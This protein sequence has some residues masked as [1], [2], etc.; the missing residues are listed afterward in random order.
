MSKTALIWGAGGGIGGALARLLKTEDWQVIA[1]ARDAGKIA[2]FAPLAFEADFG[3][4]TMVQTVVAAI[5]QRVNTVDWW[6]YAAGD[7]VVKQ[8]RE[9]TPEVWKCVLDANLTGVFH[10]AHFSLPLLSSEAPLYVI[11]AVNERM[12]LPG[13]SA[14]VTAK[15]GLEA[16]ADVLRK[17]LRRTVLVVRPAAVN[18]PLWN[19]VPFNLPSNAMTP[20]ALAERMLQAYMQG[21]KDGLMDVL[22]S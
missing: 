20:E 11:G 3:N 17:E 6:I 4:P 2:E 15:A 22:Y 21:M 19:K 10:T 9:M 16:M 14:Y 8:V 12:R 13:L 1:V 7:I 5:A 18:T